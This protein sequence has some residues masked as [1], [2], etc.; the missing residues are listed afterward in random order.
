MAK[1]VA[2]FSSGAE[3]KEQISGYLKF[4]QVGSFKT[5]MPQRPFNHFLARLGCG[6]RVNCNISWHFLFLFHFILAGKRGRTYQHRGRIGRSARRQTCHRGAC[7]WYVQT[8]P[9]ILSLW[10]L[11]FFPFSFHRSTKLFSNSFPLLI[12]DR[13]SFTRVPIFGT[14][15]QPI[16]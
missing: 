2:V 4:Q 6:W 11:F 15:F 13:Q 5:T 1:S 7:V 3:Q 16:W 9:L 14:P 12:F 8:K 10:I